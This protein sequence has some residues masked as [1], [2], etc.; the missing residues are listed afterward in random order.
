MERGAASSSA[1]APAPAQK[2]TAAELMEDIGK[3]HAQK[4]AGVWTEEE[5]QRM[6][7]RILEDEG[8]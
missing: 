2:R 6:K 3:L 5:F 4:A 7:R 8:V 1:G